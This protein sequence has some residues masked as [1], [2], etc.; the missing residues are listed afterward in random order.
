[1]TLEEIRN[2]HAQMK[3]QDLEAELHLR[4]LAV[5]NVRAEMR[6]IRLILDPRNVAAQKEVLANSKGPAITLGVGVQLGK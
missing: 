6:E 2:K 3:T 4:D 5:M 1:M